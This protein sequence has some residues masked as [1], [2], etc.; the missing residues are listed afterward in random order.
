LAAQ[1]EGDTALHWA[2]HGGHAELCRLLLTYNAR[3]DVP[4]SVGTTPLHLAAQGGHLD[5]AAVLLQEAHVPADI[6][7]RV[8]T[9]VDVV[10]SF[11]APLHPFVFT[12]SAADAHHL[13]VHTLC[14]GG[15]HAAALCGAGGAPGGGAA[16][17]ERGR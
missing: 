17:Q 12:P 16:A 9:A 5:A 10:R 3:G 13:M 14:S 15:A 4:N 1:Q 6:R 2:A 11:V 7:D 8:R